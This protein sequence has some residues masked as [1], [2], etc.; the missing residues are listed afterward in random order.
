MKAGGPGGGQPWPEPPPQT[1]GAPGTAGS[2]VQGRSAQNL[3]LAN[4]TTRWGGWRGRLRSEGR[5]RR[6]YEAAF[7]TSD[8][9]NAYPAVEANERVATRASGLSGST[10]TGTEPDRPRHE[11]DEMSTSKQSQPA[12]RRRGELHRADG[13]RQV[14]HAIGA[15][16]HRPRD[17]S[18]RSPP[19][20]MGGAVRAMTSF[21]AWTNWRTMPATTVN[22]VTSIGPRC[23]ARGRRVLS[24]GRSWSGPAPCPEHAFGGPSKNRQRRRFG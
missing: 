14:G 11:E 19:R 12:A 3:D 4:T 1:V 7:E 2:Q 5:R 13:N 17:A 8:E 10:S 20:P 6:H 15:L 21:V 23:T 16:A 9:P 18:R 22:A 24:T